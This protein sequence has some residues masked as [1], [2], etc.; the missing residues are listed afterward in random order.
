MEMSKDQNSIE[1]GERLSSS[2]VRYSLN[3]LTRIKIHKY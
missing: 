2:I 3:E 1:V